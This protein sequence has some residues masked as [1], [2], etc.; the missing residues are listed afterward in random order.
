MDKNKI[1]GIKRKK[2]CIT[3]LFISLL[4][5][6]SMFPSIVSQAKQEFIVGF[7]AEFPP[8][9][10]MDENGEYTGFDLDLADEVCKRNGWTLVKRPILWD[11]KDSELE[12]VW[13]EW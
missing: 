12:T 1:N 3:Y 11:S 10:Y 2:Y 8:Y 4:F 7:D 6:G 9:G 13:A 5:F